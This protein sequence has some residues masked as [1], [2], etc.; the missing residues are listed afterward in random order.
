MRPV[1]VLHVSQP[2]EAGVAAVLRSYLVGAG[3]DMDHVVACP[4]RGTLAGDV[5]AL[6]HE[7]VPW[8]ADREPGRSIAV[9]ALTLQRIVRA[10]NPDIV[11]LHSSKA[12]LVGRL[13][14]RGRVP[15][16]FQPHAWSFSAVRGITRSVSLSWERA[17]QRWTHATICVSEDERARGHRAGSWVPVVVVATGT[18]WPTRSTSGPGP[19]WTVRSPVLGS[20][21]RPTRRRR[22][23][24]DACAGRRG[25]TC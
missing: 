11:H 25:R 16:V 7:H 21:S 12:G 14:I 10:H 8:A 20:G 18:S 1:R 23:A 22:C 15:T 4:P 19:F 9:E 17:A 3:P 2:T 5:V 24:W 13:A 6:G